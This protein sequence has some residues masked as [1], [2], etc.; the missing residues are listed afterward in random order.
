LT[1]IFGKVLAVNSSIILLFANISVWSFCAPA[2]LGDWNPQI[3]NA[4]KWTAPNQGIQTIQ[5]TTLN[6]ITQVPMAYHGG[7]DTNA[8]G[9][10]TDKNIEKFTRWVHTYLPEDYCGP[11]VMDYEQ[12]WWKEILSKD[13]SPE[14]LQLILSVYIKGMQTAKN[15]QPSAQWGYW[16][17]PALRNT[18]S[19][20]L[21]QGLSLEPLINQ[22]NALYPD[23]YNCTPGKDKTELA[24]KHISKVLEQA[25]GR[26]PVY[27]FASVRYCGPEVG[28]SDFVP[29]EIFLRQVNA[30]LR[31]TWVDKNG[32]QHRIKG[33][34]LWDAYGFSP[35]EEWEELDQKHKHYFE[36]LQALSEAWTKAMVGKN[37]ITRTLASPECT[38]GLPEP[39]N[40]S[41]A[42]YDEPLDGQNNRIH[43][44]RVQEEP[45]ESLRVPSGRIRGDR[46]EE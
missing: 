3:Y 35:K 38:F 12:P 22:C 4:I 20:W 34:I 32:E 28:H 5:Y 14:R 15:I 21:D 40:S 33:I 1:Y 41:G 26:I 2:T 23:V 24:Q 19:R 18:S 13:I 11:V 46:L 9:E 6:G 36:L 39:S 29:D 25:A 43:T 17:L 37:V 8:S 27:V 10:I 45:V 31:A 16:G 44:D 30:A 42:I 7:V